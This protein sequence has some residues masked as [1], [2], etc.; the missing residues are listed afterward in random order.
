MKE[1]N[2]EHTR[3]E[4]CDDAIQRICTTLSENG[5]DKGAAKDIAQDIVNDLTNHWGGINFTWPKDFLYK[6]SQ[7]DLRIYEEVN[8]DNIHEVARKNGISVNAVYRAIKRIR[9]VA[10]ARSQ[11]DMFDRQ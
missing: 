8:R 5:V 1:S 10:V 3:N 11:H 4:F 9:P 6:V 7:R 2:M